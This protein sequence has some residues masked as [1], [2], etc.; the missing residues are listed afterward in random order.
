ME[1]LFMRDAAPLGSEVWGQIDDVVTNVARQRLVGRRALSLFGPLGAGVLAVPTARLATNDEIY[2]ESRDLLRFTLIEQGFRLSWEDLAIAEQNRLPIEMAPVAEAASRVAR[3]EDEL[4]FAGLR[5][6]AG[7]PLAIAHWG[8][9]GGAFA[10]VVEALGRLTGNGFAPPF[11]LVLSL[12]LYSQLQRI[13]AGSFQL[14]IG[15]VREL[16]GGNVYFSPALPDGEGFLI[17]NAPYN[18]D[19]VVAQDI[20]TMYAGNEGLDHLFVVLEKIALRL[21][22]PG[23]VVALR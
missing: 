22:R 11:A 2:I 19:L 16:V 13:M 1:Q 20:T 18:M 8:E 5:S 9:S 12:P 17:A 14:E 10:S 6:F 3:K 7:D 4:I 23:S 15:H 21:R